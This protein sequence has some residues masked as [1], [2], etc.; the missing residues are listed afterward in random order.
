MSLKFS[1]DLGN[2][3]AELID[4]SATGF[5]TRHHRGL[6]PLGANADFSYSEASGSVRVVWNWMFPDHV[7]TGFVIIK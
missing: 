1:G 6:L 5:R 4:V 7:E 2:V 3:D